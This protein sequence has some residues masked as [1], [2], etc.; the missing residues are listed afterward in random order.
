MTITFNVEE[1]EKY[2]IISFQMDIMSPEDLQNINPPKVDCSKGVILL[3]RGP[4]WLYG[5]LIHVYHPTKFV[6]TYD[7][8]LQGAVIVESHTKEYSIGELI[9]I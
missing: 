8:R 7:P 1:R 9:K 5:Y 6:A 4:I 2:T 3:G